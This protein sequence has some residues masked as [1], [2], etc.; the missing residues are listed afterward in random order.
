MWKA[1]NADIQFINGMDL[2]LIN[3]VITHPIFK[4]GINE[5]CGMAINDKFIFKTAHAR[6][7]SEGNFS[8][9]V[10]EHISLRENT[11]DNYNRQKRQF[12]LTNYTYCKNHNSFYFGNQWNYFLFLLGIASICC[13]CSNSISRWCSWNCWKHWSIVTQPFT[14]RRWSISSSCYNICKSFGWNWLLCKLLT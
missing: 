3:T 14:F 12:I 5:N 1:I 11:I 7:S 13:F 2:F 4:I 10:K 6:W 8:L 9:D